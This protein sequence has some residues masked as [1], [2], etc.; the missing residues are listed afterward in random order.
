MGESEENQKL[1][2]KVMFHNFWI[3]PHKYQIGNYFID[4]GESM[5][6]RYQRS[7][8]MFDSIIEVIA[9]ALTTDQESWII[10]IG[11]NVGDT[12]FMMLQYTSANILA[13]EPTER[14]YKLL[15]KNVETASICDRQIILENSFISQEKGKHYVSDVSN[16]TAVMIYHSDE[17]ENRTRSISMSELL[18]EKGI[19]FEKIK[20]IKCDTDGYD[21]DCLMSCAEGLKKGDIWL[22][23][24]NYLLPDC[25][26]FENLNKLYA[27]LSEMGYSVFYIFDNYGNFLCK[28]GV[29]SCYIINGYLKR[30]YTEWSQ[31]TFHYV[32]ILACKSDEKINQMIFDHLKKYY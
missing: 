17:N 24:E 3:Q 11:A 6:Q 21:A 23:W 10:D 14:F 25:S 22:Y 7:F 16:G 29:D 18:S 19:C 4:L 26:N 28:G 30:I 13:V 1:L 2:Q 5:L 15:N 20:F 9:Q 31:R 32:D 27:Y 12:L 8:P